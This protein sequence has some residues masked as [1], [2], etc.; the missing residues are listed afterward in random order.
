[1]PISVLCPSCGAGNS[2][3]STSWGKNVHCRFCNA[4]FTAVDESAPAKEKVDFDFSQAPVEE[5]VL[6]LPVVR[7]RRRS[8]EEVRRNETDDRPRRVAP[9]K[10]T[11]RRNRSNP[12]LMIVT[13]LVLLAIGIGAYFGIRDLV[14]NTIPEGQWETHE[15][16]NRYKVRFPGTPKVKPGHMGGLIDVADAMPNKHSSFVVGCARSP[17]PAQKLA[18][19]I[20]NSLNGACDEMVRGLLRA[21]ATEESR[22]SI[23]LAGHPGKQVVLDVPEEK[24]KGFIRVYLV[25]GRMYFIA[26]VGKGYDVKHGDVT[27]FFDSFEILEVPS[28]APPTVAPSGKAKS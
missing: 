2:F 15:V 16:P 20:E 10:R 27:R 24:A 6:E 23:S 26:V 9:R 1:M 7:E 14:S 3:A 8:D 17:I 5:E 4:P 13:G 18:Q 12:I 25:G 11:R 19:P 22:T 21:G 28:P